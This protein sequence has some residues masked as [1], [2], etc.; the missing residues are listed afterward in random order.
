MDKRFAII[1]G[2]VVA[3]FVGF[4]LFRGGDEANAPSD[5]S[6]ANNAN[7]VTNHILGN[8]EAE[9][10]LIEYSDYQCPFC[11]TFNP[12]V[13]QVAEKYQDDIAFYLRHLPL[14][15]HQNARAA[16][17]ASEA[18]HNQGKFWEM[19]DLI[20]EGQQVWAESNNARTIFE[21]YAQQLGLDLAKF[22]KDFA[23]R[24]VN[25]RINADVAEFNKTGSA[26][27]TPAFFLNGERLELQSISAEEFSKYI[28]EAL[29]E[30]GNQ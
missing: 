14:S 13:K 3:V 29:Q 24:E 30:T 6:D 21:G 18:A 20:F 5:G 1:L 9:V 12:V 8:P 7:K 17:R 11:A 23:S 25:D 28:D 26:I 15:T 19:N 16:A 4:L 2:V 22:K 27:A 10:V